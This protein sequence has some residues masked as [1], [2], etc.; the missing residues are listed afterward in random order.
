MTNKKR[1]YRAVSPAQVGFLRALVEGDSALS[2]LGDVNQVYLRSGLIRRW[3][4]VN[5]NGKLVATQEAKDYLY[6]LDRAT[7]LMRKNVG[8]DVTAS[9][10]KLMQSRL[11]ISLHKKTA[12]AAA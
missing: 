5:G 7:I 3:G 8:G 12:R 11:R 4:V 1:Q 9:V 10:H 2:A 6:E